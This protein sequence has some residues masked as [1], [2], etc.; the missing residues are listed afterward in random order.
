MDRATI[1]G[2]LAVA[3]RHV[4]QGEG[5]IAQQHEIIASLERNGLD[6]TAAKAALLQ[7]QELQALHVADWHRLK[8]ELDE[9]RSRPGLDLSTGPLGG[10]MRNP[11]GSQG[12]P[13][14]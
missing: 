13:P 3:L 14:H 11:P 9:I 2:H 10:N 1:L 4:A 7:F 5:H 12:M 6:A 8:L